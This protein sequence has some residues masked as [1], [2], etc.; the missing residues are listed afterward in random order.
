MVF[1]ISCSIRDIHDGIAERDVVLVAGDTAFIDGDDL[2][3]HLRLALVDA[4]S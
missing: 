3:Q 1:C 4:S 2:E